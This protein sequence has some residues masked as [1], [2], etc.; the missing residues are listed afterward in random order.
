MYDVYNKKYFVKEFGFVFL[1]L[2]EMKVGLKLLGSFWECFMF[3][4]IIVEF[5]LK[6][7]EM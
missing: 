1:L 5:L 2:F 4:F 3:V 7:F 6:W